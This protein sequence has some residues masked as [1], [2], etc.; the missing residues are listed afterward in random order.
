MIF[1]LDASSIVFLYLLLVVV[2][3]DRPL[4]HF[5]HSFIHYVVVVVSFYLRAFFPFPHGLRRP[6]RAGHRAVVAGG[7]QTSL[8][9]QVLH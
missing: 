3:D 6:R 2:S 1:K 5:L 9:S 8:P 4:I 7:L